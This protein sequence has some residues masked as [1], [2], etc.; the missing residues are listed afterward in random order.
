MN[1]EHSSNK[2]VVEKFPE[3]IEPEV[4]SELETVNDVVRYATS[5]LIEN[6]VFLG[7]GTDSYWDEA[8]YL[9]MCL[10]NLDP[11]A[12]PDTLKSKLTMREKRNIAKALTKRVQERIPTA[13]LTNRA[14]FCGIEL[15]VDERVIIPRSPIGE[16]IQKNFA[17]Y[18]NGV[19]SSILDMCTG[20][21]CIAI[22]CANQYRDYEVVIDAVDISNDALEVCCYNI[23]RYG[24]EDIILPIK[25]DLF[26]SLN[27]NQRYDIIVCNPPYVDEADIE[28]M[29]QEFHSEPRL[30]LA[31]GFDGLDIVKRLLADAPYYLS[32]DGILVVEVGNSRLSLMEEYPDIKFNWVEFENGGSGVFVMTFYELQ[33]CAEYFAEFRSE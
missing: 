33:Q 5:Y 8:M 13:Y 22:A 19:P 29:P 11:P 14:W 28:D 27:K 32:E 26:N 15:Y 9:V 2:F 17:P 31:A 20:S 10:I 16:L 4:V 1:E 6:E 24:L 7:H 21:G 25:S 12:D 3:E 30:A 23:D 18:Y